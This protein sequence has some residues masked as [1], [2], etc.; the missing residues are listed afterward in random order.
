MDKDQDISA[1]EGMEQPAT[2]APPSGPSPEQVIAELKDRLLRALAETENV[3]RRSD[4]ERED[5]AKYAVANFAR[6]IVSVADNL[7]RALD[8]GRKPGES[9]AAQLKALLEGVDVTQRGL[10]STLERFGIRVIDPIG[11]KFDPN[12]HQAL[13]EVP[14]TDKE[15]G[16]VVQVVQQGYQIADRLL[17]PALVGVA[18]AGGPA[19]SPANPN[20]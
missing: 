9:E 13:F 3:R 4:K 5:T 14:D 20:P 8:S 12:L 16:T 2:G 1:A 10:L 6:D 19:P 15:A 7:K 18:K 11:Q 17:R